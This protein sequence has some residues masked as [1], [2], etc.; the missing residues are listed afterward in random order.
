MDTDGDRIPDENSPDGKYIGDPDDDN[1]GLSDVIEEKLGSNPKDAT[2]VKQ[3]SIEGVTYYLV[4][5][6]G[7]GQPDKLYI[8]LTDTNTTITITDGKY[9]LDINNDGKWEYIY[10]P[11]TDIVTPYIIEKK[12]TGGLLPSWLIT[13]LIIIGI[14]GAIIVLV[15][16]A[17]F[18]TGY[19]SIEE[20]PVEEA[21]KSVEEPKKETPT[22]KTEKKPS[23]VKKKK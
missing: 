22:K 6:N 4:D 13:L 23:V 12:P 11:A 20:I 16:A 14:I 10:D 3:I 18:K 9:Y 21:K 2:D 5:I 8:P 7:D 19:L 1:D 17:L 15:I